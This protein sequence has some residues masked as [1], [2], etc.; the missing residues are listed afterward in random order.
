V[1]FS[2]CDICSHFITMEPAVEAWYPPGLDLRN[3]YSH[4]LWPIVLYEENRT[5]GTQH[6]VIRVCRCLYL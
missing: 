1:E 4:P 6:H 5:N 2:I 3:R